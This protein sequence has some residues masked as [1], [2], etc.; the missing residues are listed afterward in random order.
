MEQNIDIVLKFISTDLLLSSINYSSADSRSNLRKR[1][2]FF[3]QHNQL[4]RKR[5][6]TVNVYSNKSIEGF[7]LIVVYPLPKLTDQEK[8]IITNSFLSIS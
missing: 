3:S 7:K 5:K 2:E 8:R 4:Q 1:S 6:K